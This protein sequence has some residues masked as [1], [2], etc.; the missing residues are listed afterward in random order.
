MKGSS[1]STAFESALIPQA[2]VSGAGERSLLVETG[3]G[4]N[5]IWREVPGLDVGGQ[6]TL[7][8]RFPA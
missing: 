6:R 7:T 1:E 4:G 3:S 5:V 8:R 2:L